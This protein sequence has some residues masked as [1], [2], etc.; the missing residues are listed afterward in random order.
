MKQVKK[1]RLWLII[2]LLA[3][4]RTFHLGP[5]IDTPHSWR[6]YDTKQY[7]DGYYQEQGGFFEPAVCWMGGHKTLILEFPLPEYLVAK[8]YKLFGP[9]VLVARLFFLIFFLISAFYLYKILRLVFEDSVIPDVATIVYGTLPLTLFYSRAVHID[10]FVFAF[11]FAMWYYSMRAIKEKK[12]MYL[13]VGWIFSCVAF[14]VKAPYVFYL[15]FPIILYAH[16]Q[17][18]LRWLLWRAWLF[19]VPVLLLYFWTRYSKETNARIPDWSVIPNFNRFTEMWY[20]YFGTWQQRTMA[21]HWITLGGRIL[22][23][24]AGYTGLAFAVFALIFYPKNKGYYF[25][26]TLLLSTVLYM[27]LFFNLNMMHD[28]YQLPFT[29]VFAVLIAMGIEFLRRRIPQGVLRTVVVIVGLLLVSGEAIRYAETN[30]YET[31]TGMQRIAEEIRK[32][33]SPDDLVIVSYGGLSPQCPLILQPAGR[34]GWSIPIH[35]IT[36]AMIWELY[37]NGGAT[38]LAVVY[39]GYFEGEFRIFFEAMEEKTGIPLDDKGAA[40]YICK[41]NFTYPN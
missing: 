7:I 23:E 31:E 11:A 34:Y 35:D 38:R 28:Y 21:A 8:L 17:G 13:I 14:L 6:Q 5:E 16:Y 2:V 30:Y 27:V 12:L 15:A 3:A 10:F 29:V 36:P 18:S 33:T 37:R 19:V 25:T 41:L 20:W 4:L 40:L 24:V 39:N 9:H 32:N 1:Y 22:N 26:L